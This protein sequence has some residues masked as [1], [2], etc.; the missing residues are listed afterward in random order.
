[1]A[2]PKDN[3]NNPTTRARLSLDERQAAARTR[4]SSALAFANAKAQE[5]EARNIFYRL[6][7]REKLAALA[8]LS[9]PVKQAAPTRPRG[10]DGLAA[11]IRDAARPRPEIQGKKENAGKMKKD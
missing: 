3:P 7:L 4:E 6:P 8:G 10:A 9:R 2:R 11:I 5:R 1:M